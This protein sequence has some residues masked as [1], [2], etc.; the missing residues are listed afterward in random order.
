MVDDQTQTNNPE[1]KRQPSPTRHE[2]PPLEFQEMESSP[3]R[4]AK[5]AKQ[6]SKSSSQDSAHRPSPPLIPIPV[7]RNVAPPPVA[8]RIKKLVFYCI[9]NNPLFLG[10]KA[11]TPYYQRVVP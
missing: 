6:K 7:E 8:K 2:A 1:L 3:K 5:L 10:K 11:L 4:A 9:L